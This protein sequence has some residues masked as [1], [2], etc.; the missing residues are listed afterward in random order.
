MLDN[1]IHPHEDH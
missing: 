1:L